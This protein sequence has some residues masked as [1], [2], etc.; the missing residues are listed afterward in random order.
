M[1]PTEEDT[2]RLDVLLLDY[3]M[4]REDERS[5]IT[6]TATIFS[7][8]AALLALLAAA[9]TQTCQLNS[10]DNCLR[11]PDVLLAGAPLLPLALFA[12]VQMHGTVTT[13]RSYY[14]RALEEDLRLYASAPL[15][16]LRTIGPASFIGIV[17]ELASMRRGRRAY[18]M[19]ANFIFVVILVVFGGIAIYIGIH[20]GGSAQVA[21]LIVYSVLA[22]LLIMEA[23]TAT[24]GGRSLF[25]A[26]A[27]QFAASRGE[28]ILPTIPAG[29]TTRSERSLTSYLLLPRPEDWSKW[30]IAPG[31][32]LAASLSTGAMRD[33]PG[34]VIAWFVLEYLIYQARYQWNDVRGI[35]DDQRHVERRARGRLPLGA[36]GDE[37]LRN[38]VISVMVATA[39]L[40][41]ALAIGCMTGFLVQVGLL[42]LAVL[43]V[44]LI[45]ESVRSLA[46]P[47]TKLFRPTGVAIAIWLLVGFGY[48][49]RA[50]VGLLLGGFELASGVGIVALSFF[51]TYG[52][53]F[54]LLTWVLDATSY[55]Q[56]DCDG[57]WHMNADLRSKPHL[58][59]L[60]PYIGVI[61]LSSYDPEVGTYA[62]TARV[63]K[64]RGSVLAPWNIA[65]VSAVLLGVPLGIAL[66]NADPDSL[67][68][69]VG[70]TVV[71]LFLSTLLIRT[72]SQGRRLL[73]VAVGGILFFLFSL[74]GTSLAF[75]GAV[76]WLAV[77]GLYVMFRGSSY[78]D[79]KKFVPNILRLLR[80]AARKLLRLIV[81][82]RVWDS[83]LAPNDGT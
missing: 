4:G 26:T 47:D 23:T 83:I 32:Y 56:I 59:A 20:L 61:P 79:L 14:L 37:A 1:S 2:R 28:T 71:G 25:I 52:V 9:A 82:R 67:E 21:M 41:A 64:G 46:V 13:L 3:E 33:W 54:V 76:P 55:C 27:R 53:M 24:I 39:R 42:M 77:T 29:S 18:R 31:A 45:Y 35:A 22:G 16:G 7:V 49:I 70:A 10:S 43:V 51:I 57:L 40:L 66:A 73:L 58:S 30:L 60:L 65:M 12:Y 15:V 63:L 78:Q 38:A 75:L 69:F 5:V 50:A 17:T 68:I 6:A 36:S 19:L 34:F 72:N 48:A 44:A 11:V 74:A 81:G 80:L 62:G 8:A